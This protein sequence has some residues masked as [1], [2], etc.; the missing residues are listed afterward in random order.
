MKH[1][2]VLFFLSG[3]LVS[4]GGGSN[5]SDTA[6]SPTDVS[7]G[8]GAPGNSGAKANCKSLTMGA[9]SFGTGCFN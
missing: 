6:S 8:G 7:A 9:I 2:L 3:A 4:C 1:L 5:Y